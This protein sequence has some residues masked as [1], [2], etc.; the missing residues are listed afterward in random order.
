MPLLWH[1]PVEVVSNP[2]WPLLNGL[3]PAAMV[4]GKLAPQ[5][6]KAA[7]GW[8]VENTEDG[9]SIGDRQRNDCRGRGR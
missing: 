9:S 8:V 5:F 2:S 4:A 3:L 1:Q 7:A 6:C